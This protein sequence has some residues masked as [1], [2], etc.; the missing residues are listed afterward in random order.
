MANTTLDSSDTKAAP[1]FTRRQQAF[2]RYY[3]KCR[4]G[5]EAARQAGYAMGSAH[6]IA[7]RLLSN[8]NIAAACDR[9]AAWE[10]DQWCDAVK[11]IFHN[12]NS[13]QA[14]MKSLELYGKAKGWLREQS[15]ADSVSGILD[16]LGALLTSYN[17]RYINTQAVDSKQVM[18]TASYNQSYVKG[19][20]AQAEGASTCEVK[21]LDADTFSPGGGQTAPAG[22]V[23]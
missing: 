21:Q 2:I 8:A 15:A 14:Q 16:K 12:E 17:Q 4:N 13:W 22:G 19:I 5:A 23:S 9:S 6:V 10:F 18:E 11:G 20:E 3:S 7:S 1:K